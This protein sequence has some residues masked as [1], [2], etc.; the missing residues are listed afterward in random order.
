MFLGN[1]SLWRESAR[2][3]HSIEDAAVRNRPK[4]PRAGFEKIR[5]N[6]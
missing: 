2:P 4:L 3:E 5:D 6:A 1:G